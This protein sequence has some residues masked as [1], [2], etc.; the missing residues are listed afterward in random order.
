MQLQPSHLADVAGLEVR[1]ALPRRAVRTVGAWCFADH[2][3]PTPPGS[4]VALAVGPHPHTG[5]STV[6][7][8]LEGTERHTDS[9]GSDQWIRPGQLNLMTAGD[10]VAHAEQGRPDGSTTHGVQLWVAQPEATRHGP[11][12]FEHHAELPEVDLG[13]ARATVL[14]GELHGAASPATVATPLVGAQLALRGGDVTIEV[15][16]RFEHALLPLDGTI[17]VDGTAVDADVL[18]DLAPGTDHLR[19]SVGSGAGADR[20]VHVMLLGGEPFGEE[21]LMWWNF[22]V[23]T[24]DE[25][26]R[27]SRDWNDGSERFGE[28]ESP[29]GRIPAPLPPWADA[30]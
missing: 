27:A 9:L 14:V 26:V 2:F 30:P 3:G 1:R 11:S 16:P 15:D 29:L 12:A 22:V 25:A 21:L 23:R 4:D 7:W 24:R 13:A 20:P 10:G 8:L 19:L 6:T 17:G 28:V 18:A 5:L